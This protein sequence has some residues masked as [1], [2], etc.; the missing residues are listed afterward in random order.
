[1]DRREFISI[2]A[3]PSLILTSGCTEKERT[4]V[5]TLYNETSHAFEVTVSLEL[6]GTLLEE[7]TLE[8]PLSSEKRVRANHEVP[9]FW[10]PGDGPLLTL[11]SS[12]KGQTDIEPETAKWNVNE[13]CDL[14]GIVELRNTGSGPFLNVGPKC[15]D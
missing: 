2:F 13:A 11:R 15:Y 3:T 4:F 9:E 12:A 10:L 8:M 7:T 5:I 14:Q 6:G 1:M